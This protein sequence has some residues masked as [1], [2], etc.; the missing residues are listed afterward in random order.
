MYTI[1]G[2]LLLNGAIANSFDQRNNSCIFVDI[3]T[4]FDSPNTIMTTTSDAVK[5][6]IRCKLLA[7]IKDF[8]VRSGTNERTEAKFQGRVS[9]AHGF[10]HG[11]PKSAS[12]GYFFLTQ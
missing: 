11:T 1:E 6:V 2:I 8:I 4:N 5:L 7:W 10:G 9:G 12:Y 3:E